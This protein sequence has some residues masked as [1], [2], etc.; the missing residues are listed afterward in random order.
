MKKTINRI[1]WVLA[2]FFLAVTQGPQILVRELLVGG[3]CGVCYNT[4]RVANHR[5][6]GNEFQPLN[7]LYSTLQ[8][9]LHI[10]RDYTRSTLAEVLLRQ[11]VAWVILEAYIA[12]RLNVLVCTEELC[13]LCRSLCLV[14]NS[15]RE[16]FKTEHHQVGVEWRRA[17]TE[18]AQA[19]HA[20]LYNKGLIAVVTPAEPDEVQTD[21]T[22]IETDVV[23]KLL[24]MADK[25]ARKEDVS[26]T[27]A[28]TEEIKE[29]APEQ[30]ES[31]KARARAERRFISCSCRR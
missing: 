17:T 21:D 15:Q 31:R 20:A 8:S 12:Y 1:A 3:R 14:A 29:N 4:H 13:Q 22:I 11:C 16:S 18:V 30:P 6:I 9:T 2:A 28:I 7:Q 10:H 5:H 26:E 23:P 24:A 25:P 19:I 27:V